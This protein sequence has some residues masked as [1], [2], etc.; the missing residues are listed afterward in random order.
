VKLLIT[1]DDGFEAD[2][3]QELAKRLSRDHEVYVVAPDSGRSCCG[4]SVTNA[5]S[6]HVVRHSDTGWSVSGTPADCIRMA[7]LVLKIQPDWILSGVNHGG[8]LGID[9]IYSG[10]VAAAREASVLGF[11]SIALSQYMRRE[12]PKDWK[13]EATV[14]GFPSIALSQYMR[15]EIPKDWKQSAQFASKVLDHLWNLPLQPGYFWNV[16]LPAIAPIEGFFEGQSHHSFPMVECPLEKAPLSISYEPDRVHPEHDLR[17]THLYQSNYQ[18]RPR[19]DGS[20]VHYCFSGHATITKLGI[21]GI[22]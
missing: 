20:D 5:D 11:P 6:L 10:T 16:N 14:L 3:L 17:S 19:Q 18:Q 4:H 1:N 7:T 8:N 9:T 2:G 15:R 12:I 21:F 13:R 22:E